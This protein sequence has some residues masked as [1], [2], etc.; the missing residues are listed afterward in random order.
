[1]RCDDGTRVTLVGAIDVYT[2][3]L[4]LVVAPSSSSE[5]I[6][7]LL[8]VCILAWGTPEEVTTDQWSDYISARTVAAL[9]RLGVEHRINLPGAPDHK[10]HIERVFGTL[11]RDLLETLPG[12]V[13]HSVADQK[14]ISERRRAEERR[15]RPLRLVEVRLSPEE[16][17]DALDVW[18][19]EV[20]AVRPHRGL[21]GRSPL[22]VAEATMH[23]R[24]V[25]PERA[26]DVS[27]AAPAAGGG[28]RLV[29]PRGVAVDGTHSRRRSWRR[30]L[31]GGSRCGLTRSTLAPSTYSLRRESLSRARWTPS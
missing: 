19:H 17:Q 10:P 29:G 8:R 21:G 15:T 30:G 24:R 16:F 7:S 18:T 12:Y 4:R 14:Q 20:Y 2:R 9:G 23:P 27:L 5:S 13:G 22:E 1:M 25:V 26:L 3:Q 11:T 6:A 31:G 28:Y